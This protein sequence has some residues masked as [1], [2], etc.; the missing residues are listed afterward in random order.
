MSTT[1]VP[2]AAQI[3]QWGVERLQPYLRNARTH[4]EDQVLEVAASIVRF[5]FV[6]PI[7]VEKATGS[8][9]AG[10]CRLRAAQRLGLKV[11]PVIPLDHLTDAERRAYIIADNKLAENAGWDEQIL[12]GEL[13]QL[14]AEDFDLGVL[15]FDEDELTGLFASS[16]PDPIEEQPVPEPPAIA[17]CRPGDL[18][19]IGPHRLICGDC[20]DPEVV[21]ALVAGHPMNVA[22]TS[23]PYASQ[24]AYDPE[25]G[26]R[27]VPPEEYGPWFEAVAANI[28]SV[29]AA[30]GSYF[31]NIKEHADDGERSLYVKDLV[32]A[33]VRKWGWRFVD[34]FC[35]RKTDNGVPGGWGNRFKNAWEPV[36]HFCRE[37]KIK[38]RPD[39]VS[40][41]SE[42]CFDYSPNNPKSTS[43]SGL[44]GTGVRGAA[45]ANG[46][47]LSHNRGRTGGCPYCANADDPEGWHAGLARPSNVI[48][49]RTE[50]A[51]GSH[52]A[53]YPR[54]LVEFFL[55][56]FSDAGDAIFDPFLGSGTTMAAAHLLNRRGYGIEISPKYCDVILLRMQNLELEAVHAES[57]KSY[58]ELLVGIEKAAPAERP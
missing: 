28:R 19:Q 14:R 51:Q 32:C 58:R 31:L 23:P 6:N 49:A 18:W 52:A 17:V 33:H 16:V 26:F 35:W 48:E 13:E 47:N 2:V 56:A 46:L 57:G 39:P 44:L 22:I 40:H 8:I 41:P 11:V 53:P 4:S 30:D 42:H 50:C 29:L 15:G 9:I 38:F 36:F 55:K 5:G 7:L 1:T 25:S 21:R 12:R 54:P 3:E 20:R 45:A 24:R 37:G 43:G 34:E 10:H 27:P